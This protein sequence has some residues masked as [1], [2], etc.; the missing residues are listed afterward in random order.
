MNYDN[1]STSI[2][3]Y[4]AR[5]YVYMPDAPWVVDKEVYYATKPSDAFVD[6]RIV[7]DGLE[8]TA[9]NQ[10]LVASGEQS[11]LQL[12]LDGHH[13]KRAIC[14]TP[15]FRKEKKLTE[16]SR[17]YFMKSEIINADDPSR[18]NLMLMVHDACAF[19]EKFVSVK[20]LETG[21]D[22]YDIVEKLTRAELGSY[23]VRSFNDLKWLYGTGCAEPRLSTAISRSHGKS[24]A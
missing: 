21:P 7:E 23:G 17:P 8:W 19:F 13:I 18:A 12:M 2:K 24:D 14:V 20:V 22:Q 11:F 4:R 5:G 16:W 6:I 9:R 1:I 15:C 10:Y 3:H